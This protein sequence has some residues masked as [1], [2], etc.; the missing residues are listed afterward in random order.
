M[1]RCSICGAAKPSAAADCPECSTARHAPVQLPAG[2]SAYDQTPKEQA[3]SIQSQDPMI[4]MTV[5]NYRIVGKLGAGGMGA[6]YRA[7]HPGL[8]R[9]A[10]IKV[11]RPELS[12]APEVVDR[13]FRE[14]R[15]ANQIRHPG[16]V[17]I[18]D[19]G[20]LPNG[21]CYMVMELL[22]GESLE[23]YMKARGA[24]PE[25]VV[26][27]LGLKILEILTAAHQKGIIHRDLKPANIFLAKSP[28]QK[29]TLKLLDFGIAKLLAQR[30][31]ISSTAD[32]TILGTPRYMSPE[33]ARSAANIDAR[34]DIYSLGVILYE[35]A[36]GAPIFQAR[37]PLE[38]MHKHQTDT[39]IP[40][41]KL[42]PQ[43]SSDFEAAIL[44]AL[45]KDPNAR[46]KSTTELAMALN[47]NNTEENVDEQGDDLSTWMDLSSPHD[48]ISF[49]GATGNT[50]NLIE[51]A[52]PSS[53]QAHAVVMAQQENPALVQTL[54]AVD[55]AKTTPDPQHP[56]E[57][58]P[59]K[60][61]TGAIPPELQR[62]PT[63]ALVRP[64]ARRNQNLVWALVLFFSLFAVVGGYLMFVR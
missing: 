56:T 38:M 51:P 32:G 9:Q 22:E 28:L 35:L 45:T 49:E 2:V 40:P 7:E 11:L 47:A 43:L 23:Q 63:A 36:T 55:N 8:G 30:K 58:S 31:G 37:T 20:A 61:P 3:Q 14:A 64:R 59:Q 53:G 13:F 57:S 44:G 39:P 42:R 52:H 17:D 62:A 41:R 24:L 12:E 25:N 10:A 46:F 27:A 48:E 6:V 50:L 18:F 15:A 1:V 4:G 34:A 33:Q 16:I 60:Q 29:T 26:T 21:R 54:P 5:G 19:L